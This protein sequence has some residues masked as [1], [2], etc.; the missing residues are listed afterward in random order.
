M[1]IFW[2]GTSNVCQTQALLQL[3]H[4]QTVDPLVWSNLLCWKIVSAASRNAPGTAGKGASWH[5]NAAK[6]RRLQ[7]GCPLR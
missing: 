7:R 6:S 4:G 2:L 3:G 1:T 5:D